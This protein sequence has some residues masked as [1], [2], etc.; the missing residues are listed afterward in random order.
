[1]PKSI[2]LW[3]PSQAFLVMYAL[4]CKHVSLIKN[5]LHPKKCMKKE[6]TAFLDVGFQVQYVLTTTWYFSNIKFTM[7][8]VDYNYLPYLYELIYGNNKGYLR[9]KVYRKA[10]HTNRFTRYIT[11]LR[12]SKTRTNQ[13]FIFQI[14]NN[15]RQTFT[16][17]WTYPWNHEI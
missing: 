10:T 17:P 2:F 16:T 11:L 3:K 14:A 4:L 7:N 13:H 9:Y 8:V 1:M 15:I 12:I 5:S 6:H